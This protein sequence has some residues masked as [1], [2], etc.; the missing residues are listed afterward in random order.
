VDAGQKH[1]L[2]NTW[3]TTQ[4]ETF[5]QIEKTLDPDETAE[6]LQYFHRDINRKEISV[7]CDECHSTHSILD[8]AKLGFDEK[9]K[10]NLINLNIKGLVTKYKTFYFPELFGN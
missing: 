6:R 7:A 1:L 4:A 5:M 10:N 3:D 2:L 8:F 9:T